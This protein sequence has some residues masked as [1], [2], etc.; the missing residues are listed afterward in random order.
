MGA[1]GARGRMIARLEP[2]GAGS[3]PARRPPRGSSSPRCCRT[4]ACRDRILADSAQGG[5]EFR[6]YYEPL[7]GFGAF[8]EH[9]RADRLAVTADLG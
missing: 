5:I 2:L 1:A 7:H 9:D 6:T 4:A 3:R 8:A